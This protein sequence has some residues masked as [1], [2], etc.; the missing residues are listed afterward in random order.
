M[1]NG[2]NVMTLGLNNL[3]SDLGQINAKKDKSSEDKELLKHIVIKIVGNEEYMEEF[4]PIFESGGRWNPSILDTFS[5]HLTLKCRNDG[6][7]EIRKRFLLT[8]IKKN[9][10]M[11]LPDLSRGLSLLLSEGVPEATNILTTFIE[12]QRSPSDPDVWKSYEKWFLNHLNPMGGL[13]YILSGWL[14][15]WPDAPHSHF[16]S[17]VTK[18]TEIWVTRPTVRLTSEPVNE[19]FTDYLQMRAVDSSHPLKDFERPLLKLLSRY[20]NP[21]WDACLQAINNRFIGLTLSREVTETPLV[22]QSDSRA[23]SETEPARNEIPEVVLPKNG[24]RIKPAM[25]QAQDEESFLLDLSALERIEKSKNSFLR[26]LSALVIEYRKLKGQCERL[27]ALLQKR[28]EQID[29]LQEERFEAEAMLSS[30][31]DMTREAR[32]KAQELQN[33]IDRLVEEG[34]Q[35]EQRSDER[36]HQIRMQAENEVNRFK[37]ELWTRLRPDLDDLIRDD[38]HEGD[39]ATAERGRSLFRRFQDIIKSLKVLGIIP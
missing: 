24:G 30:Q 8:L 1:S 5:K 18:L 22:A 28:E 9:R 6:L 19:V 27:S 10:G 15:S 36:V 38:L 31:R 16:E 13:P 23:K 21:E 3:V 34:L 26:D 35:A 2:E 39:Y 7:N 29:R 14:K 37:H 17:V 33:E 20:E 11:W 12:K 32:E 4:L 25:P